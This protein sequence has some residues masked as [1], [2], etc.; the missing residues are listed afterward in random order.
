[1]HQIKKNKNTNVEDVCECTRNIVE[2]AKEGQ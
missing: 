1:M 2:A